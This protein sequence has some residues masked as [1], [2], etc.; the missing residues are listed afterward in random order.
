MPFQSVIQQS[1]GKGGGSGSAGEEYINWSLIGNQLISGSAVWLQDLDFNVSVCTFTILGQLYASAAQEVTLAAADETHPR[2][3]VIAV[4]VDGT[5]DVVTGV[6]AADPVKPE[7]D[8]NTQ[9]EVTFVLVAAGATEPS[10]ITNTDVY[11]ED[12]EWTTV[13]VGNVTSDDTTDPYAGTKHIFFDAADNGDR[14]SLTA[15]AAIDPSSVDMLTFYIK[16]VDYG[17]I[18]TNRLRI[19]LWNSTTRVS[20]YVDLRHGQYGFNGNSVA[21]YQLVQIPIGNFIP[22]GS[23]FDTLRF[24]VAESGSLTLSFYL[25]NIK[26]QAGVTVINTT[27]YARRDEHNVWTKAQGSGITTLTDGAT[28][29]WD[30]SPGNV[31]SLTLGGDRTIAAP[32]N[33]KPGYTYLLFLYQDG[34]GTRLVTWNSVFKWAGAEAPTL[35]TTASAV[36][37]LTFVA[38]AS[39]NLHGAVGIAESS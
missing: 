28:V 5:A 36:D 27:N 11:L 21:D 31:Y 38:D 32:T 12:T 22:N 35:T 24:Q 15:A 14:I 37:I 13:E 3:D 16:N 23:Y 29:A 33:V 6:A 25:D 7:V 1:G 18:S 17:T 30:M 20:N 8:P 10:D 4:N 34:T 19:S 9:V 2:I 26:L 39:G